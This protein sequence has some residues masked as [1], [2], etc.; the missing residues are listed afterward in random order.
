M[1]LSSMD[2]IGSGAD[3]EEDEDEEDDEDDEDDDEATFSAKDETG[4]SCES[5]AEDDEAEEDED[6][7]IREEVDKSC[8]WKCWRNCSTVPAAVMRCWSWREA[9][10][11]TLDLMIF[12]PLR[13]GRTWGPA[14]CDIPRIIANPALEGLVLGGIGELFCAVSVF[15]CCHG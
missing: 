15:S 2:I 14:G 9:A 5:Q 1:S 7:R 3:D 13:T 10:A 6:M 8:W 4:M 11:V 12:W